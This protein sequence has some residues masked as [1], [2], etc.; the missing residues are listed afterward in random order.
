MGY[1][2]MESARAYGQI[3]GLKSRSGGVVCACMQEC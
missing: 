1:A 3:G 2:S